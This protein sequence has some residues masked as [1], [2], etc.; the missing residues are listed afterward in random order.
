M[1]EMIIFTDGSYSSKTK[2]CGVGVYFPNG[3][4]DNLSLELES[5]LLTNQRA[6]L[7]AIYVALK[8]VYLGGGKD[9]KITIYT[10]STY[11]IGGYT[12]KNKWDK[13]KDILEPTYKLIKM[14]NVE[15][16]HVYAT[17]GKKKDYFSVCND[18]ADHLAKGLK[19]G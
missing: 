9:K 2:R 12:K 13:N 7:Y 19:T 10:D 17:H 5:H 1:D 4:F 11:A 15:F 8:T 14:M 18:Y 3:E 16:I 6:E